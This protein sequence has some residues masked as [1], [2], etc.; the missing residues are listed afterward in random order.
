MEV[1][2]NQFGQEVALS[3]HTRP[4][5]DSL[6]GLGG[7]EVDWGRLG[8]LFPYPH[9]VFAAT[10]LVYSY[11]PGIETFPPG[12]RREALKAQEAKAI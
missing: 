12:W 9:S 1:G 10:G 5:L 4:G 7:N 2:M 3:F 8:N 6:A 11:F